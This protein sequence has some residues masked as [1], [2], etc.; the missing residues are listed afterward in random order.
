MRKVIWLSRH[1]MTQ[2]QKDDLKRLIHEDLEIEQINHT[3]SASCDYYS[4]L[5]KNVEFIKG[6]FGLRDGESFSFVYVAGVFPP[7]AIEALKALRRQ[8]PSIAFM[9]EFYASVCMQTEEERE[10][11]KSKITFRHARWTLI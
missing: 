8:K 1:E 11:G 3:W 2:D 5:E 6:I 9:L 4:D 10:D 7:V